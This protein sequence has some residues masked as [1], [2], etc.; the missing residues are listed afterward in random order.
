MFYSD[1]IWVFILSL[2]ISAVFATTLGRPAWGREFLFY[3]F[4]LWL[5]TLAGGLYVAPIGPVIGGVFWLSYLIVGAFVSLLL[6]TLIPPP[7]TPE[8][9]N[10]V[11]RNRSKAGNA[12]VVDIFFWILVSALLLAIYFGYRH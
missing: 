9:I 2:T 4:L 11:I 3:L 10:G 1:V 6:L 12:F 8:R 5:S 7:A